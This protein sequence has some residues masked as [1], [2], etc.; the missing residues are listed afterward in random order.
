MF[1]SVCAGWSCATDLPWHSQSDALLNGIHIYNHILVLWGLHAG[2]R[3]AGG[4]NDVERY[5]ILQVLLQEGLAQ[6]GDILPMRRL[7]H[8]LPHTACVKP[9]CMDTSTQQQVEE[10]SCSYTVA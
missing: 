7:C 6:V 10:L 5:Q 3:L 9:E 4:T 2:R 8:L 1:L